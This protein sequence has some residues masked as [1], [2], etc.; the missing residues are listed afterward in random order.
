[1]NSKQRR[2]QML[3]TAYGQGHV[4]VKTLA[5]QMEVSEATVR[6]DLRLLAEEN[7][8]ELVYGGATLPRNS[9]FSF[10]AK[11]QRNIEAKRVI[12]RLAA[13]LVHDHDQVFMDSGTTTFEMCPYLRRKRGLSVIVNSARLAVE[14][15]GIGGF[16]VIVLGGQY[17]GDRCDMIG[18]LA[19]ST[20]EQLRGYRAFLGADGL[21]PEF[22]VTASD[23]DSA[24]LYRLA[25]R[26]SRETVLLVD[27]AKFQSPSLYKITEF[28]AIARVVTD[29]PP[30]EDWMRFFA[31][32]Q[33]DVI[34]PQGPQA[35]TQG[36]AETQA[37]EA[38]AETKANA[39]AI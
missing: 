39:T 29:A 33:I 7:L 10:R 18:P 11:A 27:H 2:D 13:G 32:Q 12:G 8:L 15:G 25:I 17:R 22:G 36:E 14:L 3:T 24:H 35:E 23:I 20:L 31:E 26:H 28:D 30:S 38:T 21:S 37:E 4:D 6:R 1:M 34:Y 19:I 16:D 5:R 9:D